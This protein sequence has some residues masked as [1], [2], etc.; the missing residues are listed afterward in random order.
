MKKYLLIATVMFFGL[1]ILGCG[2]KANMEESQD[3]LSMEAMSVMSTNVPAVPEAKS[4]EPKAQD[5]QVT[6]SVPAPKANLEPVPPAGPYKPTPIEI[7]T[8]L[9]NA[10]LYNGSIDG[11]I[12]P[13]TKKAVEEFQKDNGLKVDGKVGP[14]TWSLLSK[15]LTAKAIPAA[16]AKR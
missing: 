15:H 5:A 9:K 16:P 11:K 2:K 3:A 1:Y 8:A 13:G 4:L 10:G 12:G 6:V 7:Q 14:K